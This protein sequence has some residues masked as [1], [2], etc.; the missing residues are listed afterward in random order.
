[1][2]AYKLIA[3][4]MDGTLLNSEKRILPRTAKALRRAADAGYIV[5]LSTGRTASEL[6]DYRAELDGVVRYGSLLSG[7]VVRDMEKG[8]AIYKQTIPVDLVHR[9]V[10]QGLAE[11]AMVQILTS[12]VAV[13]THRD[14]ARMPEIGQ[15]VYQDMALRLGYLVDDISSYADAHADEA[16]KINLHHVSQESL[17]ATLRALEGL[18]LQLAKGEAVS[19]E[20][21]PRGVTKAL[22]LRWLC[23][24]LGIGLEETIVVGD[25]DNDLEV[26]EVAGLAVAMGNAVPKAMELADAVV[27]D[28]DHDGIA[29]VVERWLMGPSEI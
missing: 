22:G 29:E 16:C 17:A 3:L 2:P 5:V 11:N 9:V 28:N 7:G 20:V 8:K 15:G 24:H 19:V 25:G 14:V 10:E 18:P 27:A 4:D 12:E 6:T 13:M 21:T 23:D 1:M 26:L